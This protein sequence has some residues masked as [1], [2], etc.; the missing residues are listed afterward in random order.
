MV[1]SVLVVLYFKT[2]IIC[3]KHHRLRS[4]YHRTLGFKL[5]AIS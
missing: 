3:Q 5:R 1:V 2:S 4:A